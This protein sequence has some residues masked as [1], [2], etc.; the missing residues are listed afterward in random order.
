MDDP[1]QPRSGLAVF[2]TRWE[3]ND[4]LFLLVFE[5]LRPLPPLADHQQ[6]WFSAVPNQ[7]RSRITTPAARRIRRSLDETAFLMTR[8]LTGSVFVI[9]ALV[10]LWRVA[11]SDDPNDWLRAAFLTLAWFWLLCPTLNPWYWSWVLPLLPWARARAWLWVSGLVLL[12]YLRFWLDYHYSGQQV[13]GTPYRGVDF[14][15]F[16]V[17]WLEHAPLLAALAW[18]AWRH[19]DVARTSPTTD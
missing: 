1:E 3:M 12:Y 7:W 6:A 11:G 8:V 2:L 17:T 13:A 19:H 4:F 14:F 16:V 10:L 15:D 9:V 18:S 5:N